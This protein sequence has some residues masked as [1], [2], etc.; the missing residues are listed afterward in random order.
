MY[1]NISEEI[2]K[3]STLNAVRHEGK[4]NSKTVLGTLLGEHQELRAQANDLMPMVQAIVQEVNSTS[5]Q[6]LRELVNQKWADQL[7]KQRQDKERTLPPL[8]NADKYKKIVTR[9][10]PIQTLY[11]IW[12]TRELLS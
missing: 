10:A 2:R 12:V 11:Y 8:T 4:A 7:S 5:L 3:A 9:V 1:E 6:T